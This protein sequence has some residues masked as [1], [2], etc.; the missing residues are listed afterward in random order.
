MYTSTAWKWNYFRLMYVRTYVH[1]YFSLP[2]LPFPF[3]LSLFPSSSFSLYRFGTVLDETSTPLNSTNHPLQALRGLLM[4]CVHVRVCTYVCMYVHASTYMYILYVSVCTYVHL[5][6]Y[7]S[8]SLC[9][10]V[11]VYVLYTRY[12]PMHDMQYNHTIP[13]QLG[14]S[15]AMPQTQLHT[16][17]SLTAACSST[18]PNLNGTPHPVTHSWCT[19]PCT[20]AI[21]L[22]IVQ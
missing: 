6:V 4:V 1:L 17:F 12:P 16:L 15:T 7:V 10:Y 22:C 14:W 2:S 20:T 18:Q 9:M 13:K 19:S 5:C 11:G 3:P 21:Q 8:V